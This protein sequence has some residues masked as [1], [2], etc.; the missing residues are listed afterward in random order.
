MEYRLSQS[1]IQC[2]IKCC[3]KNQ[4]GIKQYWFIFPEPILMSSINDGGGS[5][6]EKMLKE[7][8]TIS[9]S[10]TVTVTVTVDEASTTI[11]LVITSSAPQGIL[12]STT[13][14]MSLFLI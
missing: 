12:F 7:L 10:V 4:F 13:P 11:V 5:K 8:P 2:I 6:I 3:Y 1:L 9:F 14:C